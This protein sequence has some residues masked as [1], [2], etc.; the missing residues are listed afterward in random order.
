[1]PPTLSIICAMDENRLI[2]NKN[3]L[4]WQL[5][6]DLAFFKKTTMNKPILMGRKTF[7][8]IGRPLPGRRNIIITRDPLIQYEGCD[9]TASIESALELVTDQPEVMLIGGASL[10][11]QT[12]GMADRLYITQI[13]AKFE[14][15]AWF[16]AIDPEQWIETWRE[17]HLPDERNQ[18]AYS[19]VN[20]YHKTDKSQ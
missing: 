7:E 17:D 12:I 18:Y 14:G 5:P 4:P 16:P 8:S 9:T 13:H 1:M 15:D 10:Y 11:Q 2:G 6:A 3:S 19:F 20:Y